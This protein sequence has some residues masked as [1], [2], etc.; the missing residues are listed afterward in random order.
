MSRICTIGFGVCLVGSLLPPAA[1]GADLAEIYAQ[2]LQ[3]DPQYRAAS[4]GNR[5]TREVRPQALAGLRPVISG[6]GE[7]GVT[8]RAGDSVLGTPY[9]PTHSFTLSVSQPVWRADRWIALEQADSQI[10]QANMELAA[11]EQDLMVRTG[12]RYFEL[13]RSEDNLEFAKSTKA[14]IAR[15]LTQAKQRFEVGLIAITDVEE[16][17]A[18]ADVADAD[19]IA[20]K[21]SIGNAKEALREITA[22]YHQAIAPLGRALPLV[23]PEPQ[24]ID[25]W[26]ETALGQNLTLAASVAGAQTAMKEIE[27]I[28]SG[29]YPTV[30]LV[31]SSTWSRSPG[32]GVNTSEGNSQFVGIQVAVPLYQGHAV[33]SRTEA[34]RHLYDQAQEQVEQA[35]RAVQRQTRNAYLGVLSGIS[36]VRALRQSVVSTETAVKATEA[37]FLAGTRTTVDVLNVQRD[38]FRARRDYK[39]ARYDYI[40][41]LLQ[42]KQSAGTLAQADIDQINGW[43]EQ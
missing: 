28:D 33:V 32:V 21:N 5:A 36:R 34:A 12:T 1:F 37:G 23:I 20:A 31:G 27:R 41:N 42:L 29:H 17:K 19:Q 43:L 38:A 9:Y 15:Q 3:S 16:A 8:R 26:T 7:A 14:A 25:Q 2:A 30:D 35:R 24:E 4:A 13:L 11:A 40:L 6:S 18:A 39:G 10:E 22:E